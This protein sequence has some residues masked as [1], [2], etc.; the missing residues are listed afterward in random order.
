MLRTLHQKTSKLLSGRIAAFCVKKGFLLHYLVV[1]RA[2]GSKMFSLT[3]SLKSLVIACSKFLFLTD[4]PYSLVRSDRMD[5]VGRHLRISLSPT[6]HLK[7]RPT[8][9]L[10]R[11]FS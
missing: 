9:N 7:A 1:L 3:P 6:L 10:P 4:Q 11:I 8:E 5:E 2:A